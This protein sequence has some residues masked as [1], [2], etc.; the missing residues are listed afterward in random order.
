MSP[1][2][3]R[4]VMSFGHVVHLPP[5]IVHYCTP[6]SVSWGPVGDGWPKE[7]KGDRS[8]V[9]LSSYKTAQCFRA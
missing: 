3:K 7:S 1:E 4:N 9:E 5:V 2:Y 6:G 8:F